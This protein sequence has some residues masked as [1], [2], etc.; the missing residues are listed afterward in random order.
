MYLLDTDTLSNLVKKAPSTKLIQRL[1]QTPV[2]QQFTTAINIGELVYGVS[3]KPGMEPLLRKLLDLI[4]PDQ[5]LPF[6]FVTAQ[7]YGRLRARLEKAGIVVAEADLRIGAI[8]LTHRLTVV[9]A[10][11]RHF[12]L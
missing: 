5:V 4:D 10:N 6:D 11:V 1:A 3:R 8:A 2:E 7:T 12:A 9:T